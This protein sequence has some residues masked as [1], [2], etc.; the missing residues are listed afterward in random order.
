MDKTD[1]G[2]K[3]DQADSDPRPAAVTFATTEHFVGQ[4]GDG[5]GQ[6]HP[7]SRAMAGIDGRTSRTRCPASRSA[8]KLS[9]P[10]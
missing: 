7:R 2:N 6:E 5:V 8:A 4:L 10:E 1:R 3:P 9:L